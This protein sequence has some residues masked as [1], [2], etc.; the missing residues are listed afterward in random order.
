MHSVCQLNSATEYVERR[1]LA[2]LISEVKEP[3]HEEPIDMY[4]YQTT[5]T[6]Q[7]Y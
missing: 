1:N 5:L 2:E 6:D 3:I 4:M 7:K